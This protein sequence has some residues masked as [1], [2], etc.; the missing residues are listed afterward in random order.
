MTPDPTIM[1]YVLSDCGISHVR[2]GLMCFLVD[3]TFYRS[4]HLEKEPYCLRL[5]KIT[6]GWLWSLGFHRRRTKVALLI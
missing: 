6:L 2:N 5:F 1:S 3:A 4:M